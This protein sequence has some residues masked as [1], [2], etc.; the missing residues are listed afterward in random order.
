[1]LLCLLRGLEVLRKPAQSLGYHHEL[2]RRV[3]EGLILLVLLYR[4][5]VLITV[6]GGT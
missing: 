2:S 6:C 5:V 4:D 1:M 3:E